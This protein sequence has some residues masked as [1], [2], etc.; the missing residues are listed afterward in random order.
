[1]HIQGKNR[2]QNR[3]TGRV[4]GLT[5]WRCKRLK[6]LLSSCCEV[7]SQSVHLIFARL[8]SYDDPLTERQSGR[9]LEM[10]FREVKMDLRSSC[11][12]VLVTIETVEVAVVEDV[13]TFDK[14]RDVSWGRRSATSTP[15][16]SPYQCI[17]LHGNTT[18]VILVQWSLVWWPINFAWWCL[19]LVIA[20][21]SCG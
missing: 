4:A 14:S 7:S 18:M 5:R 13:K 11:S 6:S 9:Q 20:S 15:Q 1:M 10:S 19:F 17:S 21:I 8:L 2:K 3:A 12:S 16:C